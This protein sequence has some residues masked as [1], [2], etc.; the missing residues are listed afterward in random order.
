MSW[1]DTVSVSS[2]TMY[3]VYCIPLLST[4]DSPVAC[5]STVQIKYVPVPEQLNVNVDVL[6]SNCV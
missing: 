3:G 4:Y 6:L 1:E 2:E 5:P